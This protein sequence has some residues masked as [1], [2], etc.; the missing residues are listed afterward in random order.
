[1]KKSQ[2]LVYQIIKVTHNVFIPEN[3]NKIYI[4]ILKCIVPC[5]FIG[6]VPEK[7]YQQ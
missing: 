1:M 6:T 7:K 2:I 3:K 4:Y 5:T